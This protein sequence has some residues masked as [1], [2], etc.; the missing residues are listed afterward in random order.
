MMAAADEAVIRVIG[1]GG[2]GRQPHLAKDPVPVACEIVLALQLMVTRQF[3]A[4]DPMV[5][6]VGKIV[7]HSRTTSSSMTPPSS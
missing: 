3:N 2:H 5:L 6:T 1:A 4:M 7:V